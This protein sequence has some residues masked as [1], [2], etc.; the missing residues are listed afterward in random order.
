MTSPP[1]PAPPGALTPRPETARS[2]RIEIA[3]VFLVTLGSSGILALLQLIDSLQ[4]EQP[5]AQ[6]SVSIV[7]QRAE[8]PL[9]DLFIQLALVVRG[10]A[11]G[12]LGL[13]L[14]WRAGVNLRTR[15]GLDRTRPG[16]DALA[17][18]GLAAAI[19]IPGLAFYLVAVAIG[20]NLTVAVTTLD[21]TW[22]R[23]PVLVFTAF[24]NGFLEEI[25]VVGYLL[26]RLDQLGVRPWVAIASS[27]VLR[28]SYHLYQGF[29]GFLGNA[30]MG[31]VFGYAY[32]RWGRIW[33][34]VIAHTLL[35]VVSF[36]GYALLKN[37]VSWLP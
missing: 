16:K 3:L 1:S 17:G 35:D 29:G 31:V 21:D 24:E 9:L 2:I 10:V 23:I 36:V 18:V 33:P 28:G 15:L 37:H 30:I 8:V 14:L 6:Q 12:G 13:Y 5:L 7:V 19:G 26:T 32:R 4:K 22:W 11:W 25:L 20:I 34:L 27:A